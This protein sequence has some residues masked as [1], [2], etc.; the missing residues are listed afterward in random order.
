MKIL[1]IEDN[2]ADVEMI[3]VVLSDHQASSL[4]LE[5]ER[6]LAAGI[7]R[8]ARGGIGCILLD[9]GL[10]DSQGIETIRA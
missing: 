2:P 5:Y 6:T 4:E 10:P 7:S 3:R 1:V 9:L 8:L